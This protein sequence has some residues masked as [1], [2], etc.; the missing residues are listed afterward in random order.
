VGLDPFKECKGL[1]TL[2][3]QGTRVTAAKVE[4]LHEALPQCTIVWDGGRI[5]P[6]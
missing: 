1:T 5:G 4:E 2:F 6:Q 3:V